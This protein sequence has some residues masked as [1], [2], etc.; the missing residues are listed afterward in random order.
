[1]PIQYRIDRASGIIE[2]TWSGTITIGDLRDF[3]R[4]CLA[5]ADV[6]DLRR[7]VVDLREADIAFTGAELEALIRT[8]VIPS[9]GDRD[10][11]TAIVVGAP[12][13]FGVGRQ[14]Q[15]FAERYSKDAIFDHPDKAKAWLSAPPGVY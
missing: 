3:W 9:L 14:Y 5:D 15:A 8:L 2:E 7:T 10:W 6:L 12:V 13:Q 11:R 4:G 1:M